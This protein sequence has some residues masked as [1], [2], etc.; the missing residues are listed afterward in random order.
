MTNSQSKTH[1]CTQTDSGLTESLSNEGNNQ[2]WTRVNSAV[3]KW[4]EWNGCDPDYYG[5]QRNVTR[6]ES[7]LQASL[8]GTAPHPRSAHV[9]GSSSSPST[10]SLTI[11]PPHKPLHL[12][13]VC[14]WGMLGVFS[15]SDRT[16]HAR[17]LQLHPRCFGSYLP[18]GWHTLSLSLEEDPPA[19]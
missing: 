12:R 14:V 4:A 9:V 19:A 5:L 3:N 2:K 8:G 17:E 10:G 11:A 1:D 16:P 6:Q 15:R 13:R 7:N 18:W